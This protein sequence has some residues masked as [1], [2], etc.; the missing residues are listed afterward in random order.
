VQ[1][2]RSFC[3]LFTTPRRPL[4][5]FHLSGGS[6][7]EMATG[8][9]SDILRPPVGPVTRPPNR[10]APLRRASR[11]C[12]PHPP[13]PA[14]A[15]RAGALGPRHPAAPRR[16]PPPPRRRPPPQ[17]GCRPLPP[18]PF[19]PLAPQRSLG[20]KGGMPPH[21]HGVTAKG[22]AEP[23]RVCQ[24][25]RPTNTTFSLLPAEPGRLPPPSR[26]GGVAPPPEVRAAGVGPRPL[27]AQG[28]PPLRGP[29]GPVRPLPPIPPPRA[30]GRRAVGPDPSHGCTRDRHGGSPPGANAAVR[31]GVTPFP[32][33]SA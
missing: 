21:P 13:P 8:G 15:A 2:P 24:P 28:Q 3:F 30:P 25:M 32:P 6:H 26:A 5:P 10:I 20:S 33:G 18:P 17:R 22:F 1:I 11:C 7:L 27:P 31:R 9:S 29:L 19:A 16:A 14:A 12:G 23:R 4:W